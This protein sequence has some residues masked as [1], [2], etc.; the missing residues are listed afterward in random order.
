MIASSAPPADGV[1]TSSTTCRLSLSVCCRPLDFQCRCCCCCCCCCCCLLRWTVRI[2]L[3]PSIDFVGTLH[4]HFET[5]PGIGGRW[6]RL[7]GR[8]KDHL[9]E[10]ISSSRV[11]DAYV[12]YYKFSN[13]H[14]LVR[15]IHS[16]TVGQ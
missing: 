14:L 4:A 12:T 1:R 11:Y 3:F 8:I 9:G 5:R 15:F 2:C 13:R 6:L 7:N 10:L 16:N